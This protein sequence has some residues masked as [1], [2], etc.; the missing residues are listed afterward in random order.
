M[1]KYL[2]SLFLLTYM[3]SLSAQE[4][5]PPLTG[6]QWD[7]LSPASLGWCEGEID[8]LY[9]YLESKGTK[10][11]IVLKGGKIV[12]EKYFGTFQ[13]DSLWYWASAGK[14]LTSMLVGIAQSDGLVGLD[15]PTSD[16]LGTGWTSATATQELAITVRHQLSMSTGLD[17][18]VIDLNC[19]TP[20]C[21]QFL[22]NPYD[23]WAYYNAPYR[24][25]LDVLANASGQTINAFTREK[26][27]DKIGMG[28][29]WL[30]Y[31]RYGKARDMARF[32][33][34]SL[35]NGVW[36]SDTVLQ[37]T[38]YAR[39]MRESSQPLNTAYGY[40]WWLNGTGSYML[41]R[42]QL[43]FNTN[44]IP[45]APDDLYAALGKNDQ[46]IYVIP[47][48][49]MVVV[50]QGNAAGN[51]LFAL[52]SFDNELW[53]KLNALECATTSIRPDPTHSLTLYPNPAHHFLNIESPFPME[54]IT[55]LDLTGK[56]L[57]SVPVSLEREYRLCLASLAPGIYFLVM[58]GQ[59]KRAVR[60]FIQEP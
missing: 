15:S 2:L 21:L 37:D 29:F 22:T 19:L 52:S 8:S 31:V 28:G 1:Y 11:F 45:N 50:R 53:G 46:K 51:S 59:G 20:A 18:N 5:T 23:R 55:V 54:E 42:V 48:R 14:S 13:P 4:Y 34:L 12:L 33:L 10:S 49:D 7:T 3:L 38:A 16:Y 39:M 30:N 24:L 9:S 56:R 58:E 35:R 44:L 41:P 60:R 25:L 43:L 40:L 57:F 32:G 27:G 17:D 47:S 6:A 26:I 36:G